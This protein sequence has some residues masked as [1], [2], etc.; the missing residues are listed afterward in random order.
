V[1]KGLNESSAIS[2]QGWLI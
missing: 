1:L 2:S